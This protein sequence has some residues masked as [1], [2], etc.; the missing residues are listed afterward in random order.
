MELMELEPGLEGEEVV[1]LVAQ[2]FDQVEVVVAGLDAVE[3]ALNTDPHRP[4]PVHP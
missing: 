3:A 1:V 4:L 2:Q